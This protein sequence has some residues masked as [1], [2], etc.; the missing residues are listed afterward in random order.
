MSDN[1]VVQN[2][3]NA[4]TTWN[5]KLAEIWLLITQSPQ[6]FK[7]GSIWNV[8]QG[9]HGAVQAVGLALL[10]LFFVV[11][12]MKT[13]GSFAEIKRPEQALKLFIRFALAKGL[14]TY[15]LELMM[16]LF[17]I[18]QGLISTIMGAAGF[19]APQETILPQEIINAIEECGF[20]ESVPLWAVT[21]I[22]SL[23]ITV[24]SFVMVMT[25]YGRFFKLY[26]YTAI[27]PVPLAAFAGESTQSVGVSFLK[28]Y[29]AVCL[30]GAII[31]LGCIIFSVFAATPPVIDPDAA[32]VSMV[33]SYVGELIF[34]ML[35]LVGTVKMADRV[36]REMMGL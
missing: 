29:A 13:C 33:W 4:L 20:L 6:A 17:Q 36:V 30:E 31:V 22:G 23:F 24:L 14:V 25:V 18:V 16:A 26:L 10:V 8:M 12:V 9:I 19:G 3:S 28:S 5:E 32:A 11:G 21:L 27:A 34:N 15:G 1:W 2:L 35:V 7:G